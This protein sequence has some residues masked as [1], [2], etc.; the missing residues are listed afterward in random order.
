MWGPFHLLLKAEA[1]PIVV[2]RNLDRG[3]SRNP[4][5]WNQG[6][7]DHGQIRINYTESEVDPDLDPAPDLNFLQRKSKFLQIF[8]RRGPNRQQRI[9]NYLKG[10]ILTNP[11]PD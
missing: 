5:F 7:F 8:L 2:S 4:L 6:L 1:L 11:D 9:R 3:S 10:R